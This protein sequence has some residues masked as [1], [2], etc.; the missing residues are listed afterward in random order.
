LRARPAIR[1]FAA[2]AALWTIASAEQARADNTH[3]CIVA[4]DDGQKL[5][6]DRRLTLARERF[7]SCARETCPA[8]VRQACA[9]WQVDVEARMPSV[10]FAAQNSMGRDIVWAR[11]SVDGTVVTESLNGAAVAV[12]PGPH[13]IRFEADGQVAEQTI[14]AR[15]GEKDRVVSVTFPASA[16]TATKSARG[17]PAPPSTSLRS[18]SSPESSIS[19]AAWIAGI[20]GIAALGG[21]AFFGLTGQADKNSLASSCASTSTCASHEVSA[22]RTKLIVA[23]ALLGVG[24]VALTA[25]AYLVITSRPLKSAPRSRSSHLGIVPASGGALAGW[26]TFF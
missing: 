3:A 24:V 8:P 2:S 25:A 26:S 9:Q 16:S 6:D 15:E 20:A 22:A 4:S 13:T 18:T 5:R 7:L 10:V 12:D 1:A 17:L 11:V 21:F 19:T 23:D 14:V